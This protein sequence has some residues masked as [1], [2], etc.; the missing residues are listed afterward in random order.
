MILLITYGLN[1]TTTYASVDSGSAESTVTIPD[2]AAA[3]QHVYA[4]SS[5][6]SEDGSQETVVVT[7]NADAG[8]TGLG[9]RI[10]FDSSA[11][12]VAH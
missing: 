7:Y 12:S 2:L 6:K 11:L 8:N 10:H 4:S 9:L 1:D 5:T 3:T